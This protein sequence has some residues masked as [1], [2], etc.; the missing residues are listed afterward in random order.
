LTDTL[1]SSELPKEIFRLGKDYNALYENVAN[2]EK[3]QQEITEQYK[4]LEKQIKEWQEF[5]KQH[6]KLSENGVFMTHDMHNEL[7]DKADKWDKLSNA[8][9]FNDCN[10]A[11]DGFCIFEQ[12]NEKLEQEI[13]SLKDDSD[14]YH[15]LIQYQ[16]EHQKEAE[17]NKETVSKVKEWLSK[18]QWD[19]YVKKELKEILE[20]A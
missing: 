7:K 9:K 2:P 20:K 19:D 13:K 4:K 8:E 5:Y 15:Q 12:K 11:K 6:I 14:K 17:K 10:P 16:I 18:Y 1:K 3:Q